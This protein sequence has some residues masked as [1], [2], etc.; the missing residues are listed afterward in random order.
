MR[1]AEEAVSP[2]AADEML[3]L[4]SIAMR[5]QRPVLAIRDNV[6]QLVFI[7]EADSEIWGSD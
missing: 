7:D 3:G 5:T 1:A 6:T 4:E 2:Q